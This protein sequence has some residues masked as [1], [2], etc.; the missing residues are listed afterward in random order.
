VNY[1]SVKLSSIVAQLIIIDIDGSINRVS[2]KMRILYREAQQHGVFVNLDMEEYRDLPMTV[3][4][5]MRVLDEDEFVAIKAGIVLQAYLP[6]AHHFFGE[7]V[8]WSK[9]RYGR[10][11]A[12]IKVRLVKGANLAMSRSR[13][14]RLESGPLSL[15]IRCRC[16]ICSTCR[17]SFAPRTCTGCPYWYRLSQSISYDLGT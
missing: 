1:I 7:L 2:E 11:G 16:F 17:C 12:S 13:T 15:K 8:Q 9:Q 3:A 5:F 6:E 4:A 10:S 14:S